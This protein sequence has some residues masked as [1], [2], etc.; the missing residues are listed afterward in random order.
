[1]QGEDCS[2]SCP[3]GVSVSL[4]FYFLSLPSFFPFSFL[5]FPFFSSLSFPYSFPFLQF[6]FF[7]PNSFLFLLFF[8]FSDTD[9]DFC[10]LRH[11]DLLENGTSSTST[12]HFSYGVHCGCS[13]LPVLGDA[14]STSRS[15]N[16]DPPDGGEMVSGE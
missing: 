15:R 9:M 16:Q 7:S 13:S 6:F 1:M 5:F 14:A 11:P 8:F 3:L 10:A 2:S 4:F 12:L